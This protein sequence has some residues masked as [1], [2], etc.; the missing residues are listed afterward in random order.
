MARLRRKLINGRFYMLA[1]VQGRVVTYQLKPS[2]H[3][4]FCSEGRKAGDY[5][6]QTEVIRLAQSGELY[7][8]GIAPFV[9]APHPEFLFS[10][11]NPSVGPPSAQTTESLEKPH[12]DEGMTSL[13]EPTSPEVHPTSNRKK[14]AVFLLALTVLA[15]VIWVLS[16]TSKSF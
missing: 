5:I 8:K 15:V 13:E 10:P 16:G 11:V 1:N 7:T 3:H 14:L 4:R 12:S 9:S 2:L 6:D